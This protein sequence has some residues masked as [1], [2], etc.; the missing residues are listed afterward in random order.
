MFVAI[1]TARLTRTTARSGLFE[2][3]EIPQQQVFG[4][5]GPE[6]PGRDHDPMRDGDDPPHL[7]VGTC[8]ASTACTTRSR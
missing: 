1:Q 5:L 8:S 2:L 7:R 6:R 4:F 3:T